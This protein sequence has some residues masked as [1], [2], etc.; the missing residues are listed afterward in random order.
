[1]KLRMTPDAYIAVE[2]AEKDVLACAE[3]FKGLG[4]APAGRPFQARWEALVA[5]A[6]CLMEAKLLDFVDREEKSGPAVVRPGP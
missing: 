5:L 4:K 3:Y 1:M 6:A 2:K